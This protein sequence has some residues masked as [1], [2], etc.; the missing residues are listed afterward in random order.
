MNEKENEY[1]RFYSFERVNEFSK[2][3]ERENISIAEAKAKYKSIAQ[4]IGTLIG[5]DESTAKEIHINLL[6][7]INEVQKN[8]QICNHERELGFQGFK[9]FND[10]YSSQERVCT[11]CGIDEETVSWLFRNDP[12]FRDTK[13]GKIRGHRL[14]IDKINPLEPYSKD[15]CALA[16]YFCNNDKSDFFFTVQEYK[17]YLSDRKAYLL[18]K[19]N[20]L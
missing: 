20:Q 16:C 18:K 6:E 9:A 14:E 11:Y 2:I 1:L 3:A 12:K 4:Y 8:H 10:W 7:R 17:S 19:R 13:R 15:N 5:V